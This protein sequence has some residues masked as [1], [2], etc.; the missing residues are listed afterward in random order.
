[1]WLIVLGPIIFIVPSFA[2]MA[3]AV[4]EPGEKIEPTPNEC[5]KAG[6]IYYNPNDSAL[7]VERRAGLGYT[8]NFGNRWSWVLSLGLL[9]I[10]GTAPLLT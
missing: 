4:A 10:V 3:H 6:M 8:F 9:L 2:A 7:F 5:W 1:M